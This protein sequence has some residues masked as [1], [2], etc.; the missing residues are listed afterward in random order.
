MKP[1]APNR[2]RLL[3][4]CCATVAWLAAGNARVV[5][6]R[7][8]FPSVV[9]NTSYPMTPQPSLTPAPTFDPYATPGL[10][11]P[12]ADIPYA[13][14]TLTPN[15]GAPPMTAAP[16]LTPNFGAPPA[17]GIPYAAPPAVPPGGNVMQHLPSIQWN[18][19]TYDYQ[20]PDGTVSR[21]QRFLQQISVEHTH[22]FGDGSANELQ[23]DR[24]ELAA[25]FGVPIFANPDTPL[26]ITPGFAFNWLEGPPTDSGADLPPRV[27]DAYLDTAWYPRFSEFLGA[28]LGV[29][30]GVWTDFHA[31]N[32]D[33]LRIL[34]RGLG[35]I[36]LSP[37][38]DVHVGVWY[39]DRNHIKLLPAGGVHWRPNS[40]WDA[41]LVFPNPKVRKRF[42]NIGSSQWWWYV[43]GEYGGGRWTIERDPAGVAGAIDDDID[44]NDIRA[45]LGVEFETQT[46][47]HGRFEVG[48]VFDREILY[49]SG[50]PPEYNLDDTV[51]LRAGIDF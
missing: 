51:M 11:A 23:V 35:V 39:L 38:M 26:L 49:D 24:L 21:L 4:L 3:S 41:F 13:P 6:Q 8:Q 42:I 48:Y 22:L 37:K 28:D 18:R 9:P 30:T 5:A 10:G 31:V 36:K 43:A 50:E 27:Y 34:G 17:T 29:R 2:R 1:P 32:S 7:V 16:T 12:P 45:I 47:M 44:Y 25:T 19:G 33:S 20:N 15:F 14:P 46:R 40:E